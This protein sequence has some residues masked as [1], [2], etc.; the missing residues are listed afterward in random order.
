MTENLHR[1]DHYI[2]FC[3]HTVYQ[4]VWSVYASV[5]TCMSEGGSVLSLREKQVNSELICHIP[6]HLI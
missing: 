5:W 6:S 4:G 3:A 2:L 1:H